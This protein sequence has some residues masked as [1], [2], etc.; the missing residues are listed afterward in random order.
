MASG[1]SGNAHTVPDQ[2]VCSCQPLALRGAVID[3]SH[4][5]SLGSLI[6]LISLTVKTS[7]MIKPKKFH[8]V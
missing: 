6:D 4:T 7:H 5:H 3:P 2:L 8:S 1:P